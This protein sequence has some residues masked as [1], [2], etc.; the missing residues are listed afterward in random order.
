M[1]EHM[2]WRTKTGMKGCI[3]ATA[4]YGSVLRTTSAVAIRLTVAGEGE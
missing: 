4:N 3:T 1:R 2:P